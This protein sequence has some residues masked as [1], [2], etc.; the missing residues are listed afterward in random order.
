MK[1]GNLENKSKAQMDRALL[2]TARACVETAKCQEI[3]A[4]KFLCLRL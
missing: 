1:S 4:D 3:N 2:F